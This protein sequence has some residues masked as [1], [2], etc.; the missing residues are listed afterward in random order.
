MRTTAKIT[1]PAVFAHQH[2]DDQSELERTN[3]ELSKC[4]RIVDLI[5]AEQIGIDGF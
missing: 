4:V 1:E 3:C 5:K 2:V